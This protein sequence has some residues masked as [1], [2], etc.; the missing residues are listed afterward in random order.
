[1]ML[2]Q[3]IYCIEGHW[4]YGKREVEPSVEPIL[5][6]LRNK[7]FWNY[8]RRDCATLEELQFWLEHEWTRCKPGSIL[9]IASHGSTGCISLAYQN[10]VDVVQLAEWVSECGSD[11]K[12]KWVHFGGCKTFS[13]KGEEAVWE[14]MES[15]GASCVTGYSKTSGWIDMKYRPAV[16]L[17]L[18][19]FAS[20]S[21]INFGDGRSVKRRMYGIEKDF[22]KNNIFR[23]CGFRALT[24]WDK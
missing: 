24:K 2:E 18:M 22:E 16:A 8:V 10:D 3:R 23:D 12:D 7:G 20:T 15:T 21:G 5:Q 6:M 1:M 4:D 19:L 13:G 11:C 9:Y 14:F 17:E